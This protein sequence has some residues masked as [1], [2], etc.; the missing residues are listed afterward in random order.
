MWL[1]DSTF[2]SVDRARGLVDQPLHSGK[3]V[4]IQHE[5]RPPAE[6]IENCR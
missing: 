2:S 5:Y 3:P 4:L 1:F 6:E